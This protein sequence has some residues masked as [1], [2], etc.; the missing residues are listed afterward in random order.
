MYLVNHLFPV[1]KLSGPQFF[2]YKTTS[3][4]SST[5]L[6]HTQHEQTEP[7]GDPPLACQAPPPEGPFLHTPR[8]GQRRQQVH[9]CPLCAV[10]KGHVL[11]VVIVGTENQKIHLHLQRAATGKL[12]PAGS[13]QE[14]GH[15]AREALCF[16]W[17]PFEDL[18]SLRQPS[19]T[20]R[21]KHTP[22]Y[23]PPSWESQ[24]RHIG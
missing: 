7:G 15:T 5:V 12:L 23:L 3:I 1:L 21:I 14:Q 2:R 24:C 11:Q 13:Q 6:V 10:T 9:L 18:G 16:C 19:S 8:A 20:S 17:P 4:K 22:M